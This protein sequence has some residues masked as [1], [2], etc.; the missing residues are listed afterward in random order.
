MPENP[1]YMMERNPLL[2]DDWGD[3]VGM[4]RRR[5]WL[6]K[7][8][9]AFGTLPYAFEVGRKVGPYASRLVYEARS[10]GDAGRFCRAVNSMSLD[11]MDVTFHAWR[12]L[13]EAFEGGGRA[14]VDVAPVDVLRLPADTVQH[15][16][17]YGIDNDIRLIAHCSKGAQK[18]SVHY[19][20]ESIPCIYGVDTLTG[21]P[22]YIKFS[23]FDRNLLVMGS[24]VESSG[25]ID[26]VLLSLSLLARPEMIQLILGERIGDSLKRYQALPQQVETC[27]PEEALERAVEV[28]EQRNQILDANEIDMLMFNY[29]SEREQARLGHPGPMK[30][31]V[32]SVADLNCLATDDTGRIKRL[33]DEIEELGSNC[34]VHLAA[35]AP[36]DSAYVTA[37]DH[38][39]HFY[40]GQQSML[41]TAPCLPASGSITC[42]QDGRWRNGLAF[43]PMYEGTFKR[44]VAQYRH[45]ESYRS[46]W[47]LR[48]V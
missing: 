44:L 2:P 28:I 33:L 35:T 19:A 5:E 8:A 22:L 21:N 42:L 40:S 37:Y 12:Q 41:P 4:A 18:L 10:K 13:P 14:V 23:D 38:F 16:I 31:V 43:K 48:D 15:F 6:D 47:W 7:A 36:V 11:L 24:R 32:V 9:R 39:V 46:L 27:S 45:D 25:L 17:E 29:L 26:S 30:M 34:G 3:P 1:W 20:M